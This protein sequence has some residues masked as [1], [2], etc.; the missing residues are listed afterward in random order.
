LAGITSKGEVPD[1][2]GLIVRG[3]K[4][5]QVQKGAPPRQ[6]DMPVETILSM[7]FLKQRQTV[8]ER[9]M[10]RVIGA[11]DRLRMSHS[12]REVTNA[13]GKRIGD[14]ITRQFEYEQEGANFKALIA[15]I[16]RDINEAL[17]IDAKWPDWE[18]IRLVREIERERERLN[19]IG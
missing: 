16:E 1:E 12:N 8:R 5:W 6:I 7:L 3:P 2:A 11:F 4:G 15:N 9:K 13:L 10:D 19:Q 17:G 14:A 18:L